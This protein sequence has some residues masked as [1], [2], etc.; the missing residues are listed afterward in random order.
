[1]NYSYSMYPISYISNSTI[2]TIASICIIFG[3]YFSI[4]HIL[5]YFRQFDVGSSFLA[6]IIYLYCICNSF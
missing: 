2:V 4:L 6:L 5:R 3:T 1:M